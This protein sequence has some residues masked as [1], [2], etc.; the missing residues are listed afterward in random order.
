MY[1]DL[2]AHSSKKGAFVFGN[3]LEGDRH[4][5]G[6]LFAKLLSLNSQYFEYGDCDF[7]QKSMLSKAAADFHSKE[8]CG[9]VANYKSTNLIHCYT[10]ESC[11]FCIKPLHTM[12]P[13]AHT[14]SG[15]LL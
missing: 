2:H 14:K 9:R 11:Y 4:I 5:E 8:G 12:P 3:A 13:L 7:S 1:L 15:K 6:L 10:V